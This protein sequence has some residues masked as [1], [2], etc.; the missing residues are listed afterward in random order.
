MH[1]TLRKFGYPQSMLAETEHWCVLLRPQQATLGA[2]V[3][4][5]KS[6][7]GS[8]AELPTGAYAEL[9]PVTKL[10]ETALRSFRSFDRINYLLLMMVDPHVHFHVVPRY[11][12]AQ[13]F[14]NDEFKDMGWPG[15]PDLKSVTA[16]SASA[17]EALY[18]EIKLHFDRAR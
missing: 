7:A 4:A 11:G 1:A 12:A 14:G 18:V 15:P 16:L 17:M 8:L 5:A 2:L 13:V 10:I 9:Q 6:E 3:L